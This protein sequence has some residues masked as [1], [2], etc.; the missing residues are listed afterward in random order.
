MSASGRRALVTAGIGIPAAEFAYTTT[1]GGQTATIQRIDLTG[2][3][4]IA[5][6]DGDITTVPSGSNTTIQHTYSGVQEY[7]V[8]I[9]G[10]WDAVTYFSWVSDAKLSFDVSAATWPSSLSVLWLNNTSVSGDVSAATWP[11]S[12][13]VLRLFS[14]SV[15][16][17]AATFAN[18]ASVILVYFYDCGWTQ[19]M[20]DNC[21]LAF[22]NHADT[23]TATGGALQL[24]GSNAAPSGTYQ[25]AA[26]C[27]VDGSTPG[28]EIAHEL[29]NDG[30]GAGINTWTTVTTS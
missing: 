20:S 13:S 1:G 22:Y 25:P 9:Y 19:A 26:S 14:T 15:T 10:D 12:L 5:W 6:G 24:D 17:D 29:I 28:K 27:P 18:G 21:L 4:R 3:I 30:C 8:G 23:R 7:N 2:S 11:S 16:F